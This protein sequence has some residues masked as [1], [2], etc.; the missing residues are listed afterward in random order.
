MGDRNEHPE[1]HVQ[2]IVKDKPTENGVR[3]NNVLTGL[4]LAA[5]LWVGTS[6]EQLK[7]AVIVLATEQKHNTIIV[8]GMQED[9]E[10]A[11]NRIG[12]L[13]RLHPEFYLKSP[14]L[15]KGGRDG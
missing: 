3:I 4:L 1:S 15:A 5:A 6:V 12:I 14:P 2:Y 9:I 11:E 10:R 7:E 13:E 8:D